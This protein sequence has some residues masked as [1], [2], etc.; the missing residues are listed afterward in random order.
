MKSLLSIPGMFSSSNGLDLNQLQVSIHSSTKLIV[1]SDDVIVSYRCEIQRHNDVDFFH[2]GFF[3]LFRETLKISP[4]LVQR[5]YES[6]LKECKK[7]SLTYRSMAIR[8]L[9][10]FASEYQFQI[11][12]LFWGWFEKAFKQPVRS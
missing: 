11:Y 1:M 12:E 7:E 3:F 10:L 2:R 6:V 9:A 5:V 8:V 4:Q